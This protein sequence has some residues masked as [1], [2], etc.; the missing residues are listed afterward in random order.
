[1]RVELLV[2]RTDKLSEIFHLVGED[3]AHVPL[4]RDFRSYIVGHVSS[5]KNLFLGIFWVGDHFIDI[6]ET[7]LPLELRKPHVER[8]LKPIAFSDR[9]ALACTYTFMHGK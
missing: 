7:G 8:T 9:K 3:W 2:L 6:G 4:E 1:M 5:L